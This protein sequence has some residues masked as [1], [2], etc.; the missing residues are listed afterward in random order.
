MRNV[1]QHLLGIDPAP[2]ADGGSWRVQFLSFPKHGGAL[3]LLAA[4]VL[5]VWGVLYLY[6]REGRNLP[7]PIRVML[8]TLRMVVL[9]GVLAMLLEPVLVFTKQEFVPSNL[10]VLSDR[11]SSMNLQ[12]AYS[13]T[14]TADRLSKSLKLASVDELRTKSRAE[15][16]DR[17]MSTGLS[18]ILAA[19]G[20]RIVKP[21]GFTS[22]LLPPL[23]AG[24]GRG[25]GATGGESRVPSTTRPIP[26]PLAGS[27]PFR[28][29]LPEGEGTE[30]DRSTTALGTAIRQAIAAHRGQPLA[31]ILLLTDG[32]SNAGEAPAKVA[33]FAAAEGVPVVSVAIGT[34]EGPRNA[35]ITKLEVSPVAFIR[36]PNPVRVIIESRGMNKSEAGVVLERSRDGGPW[37]EV[38]RQQITLQE[39]GLVQEVP[40]EIKEERPTKL[41]LRARLEDAG[42]E[43]TRDDNIGSGEMR[44]IRQ[45]I[46]A[47]FIAGST[48]PEVEFLRNALLRDAG[49]SAST[50]LQT[51]DATYEHPGNPSIKRLPTTEEE[52]NEFD[53]IIAYDPDPTLWPA[54]FPELLSNFVAKAGGGLV[55]VAGERMTKT[56]F[57]GNAD[58]P[59]NAWV[60]MLPVFS[61]PGLYRS[62][63]S[64]RLSAQSPWRLEITP[65]GK[66]DPVFQFATTPEKNEPILSNLPGMFWHFPVTRAKPGATV[67]ARHG[68]PRMRNEHGA[69]VLLATQLVGPGRT[70]FVGFD[71]TY[72][73][74]YLDEQYFDGFWARMIDRAG[75]GKQ[76]G[77]RYPYILSMDRAGYRPGSQATL[78]ARFENPLELD[79]GIDSLSGEVEVADQSPMVLTLTP[80]AGE[81]G[82]FEASF[83]VGHAGPHFLRVWPGDID[84][85]STARPATLQFDVELPNLEY[86]RPGTDLATLQQIAS[87]TGGGV[88][89]ASQSDQIA[90]AFKVKQVARTLEDRQEI[91][92]APLILGT[93]LAALFAEWVLRKK[94]R[95]V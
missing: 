34:P 11:S 16:S 15:I 7:L 54:N 91:W 76:L 78:T 10:L 28:S 23:P 94:Y 59:A 73:W 12:D 9:G 53:C 37:E 3:L 47:L 63:V 19:N 68:D 82:V 48:F 89:D 88:F 40:F 41:A 85:K 92:N 21:I 86:E 81:R 31:G 66:T 93:I 57:D 14:G 67:L 71:S 79:A 26:N 5:G 32:Q 70:I 87:I 4:V 58:D 60:R 61:E 52:I 95:M 43:L 29:L 84:A 22:Q 33:D 35:K 50:W 30:A 49:V 83:P 39:S 45:K 6:R 55:Y 2:W 80:R 46:R 24:E 1:L 77:G 75:R 36:D 62:E 27:R 20:Q 25:E 51:A 13:D 18:E 69:H 74:R 44:I 64:M 42:V 72:R 17:L 56:L 8:S 65:E 38:G 90:A